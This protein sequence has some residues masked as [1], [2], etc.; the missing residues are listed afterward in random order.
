MA[1]LTGLDRHL[2]EKSRIYQWFMR[3]V[4]GAERLFGHNLQQ[5]VHGTLQQNN[6]ICMLVVS[7]RENL[8]RDRS[9][10]WAMV[11]TF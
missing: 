3:L 8:N 7:N 6:I 4:L 2:I 5:R 10:S 1:K 9:S 11:S